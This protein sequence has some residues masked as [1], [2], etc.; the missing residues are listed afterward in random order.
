MATKIKEECNEFQ[1][2]TLNIKKLPKQR[3]KKD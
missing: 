3:E 2:K 1:C